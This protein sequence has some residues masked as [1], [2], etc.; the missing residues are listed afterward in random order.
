MLTPEHWQQDCWDRLCGMSTGVPQNSGLPKVSGQ[1]AASC[2]D[3][4]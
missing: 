3:K 2:L 1:D 4:T